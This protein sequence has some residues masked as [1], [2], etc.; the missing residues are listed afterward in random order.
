MSNQIAR[1]KVCYIIIHCQCKIKFNNPNTA[2]ILFLSLSF[3][4]CIAPG[5]YVCK[6]MCDNKLYIVV[7]L[8]TVYKLY[9]RSYSVHTKNEMVVMTIPYGFSSI[10]SL[11]FVDSSV[12]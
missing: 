6:Y 9:P 12:K 5:R 3:G 7:S 1:K 11:L 8:G 2:T 10:Y 4:G